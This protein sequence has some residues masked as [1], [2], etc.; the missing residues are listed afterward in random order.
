M[1]FCIIFVVWSILWLFDRWWV[2]VSGK[3]Q[4]LATNPRNLQKATVRVLYSFFGNF[5]NYCSINSNFMINNVI[6]TSRCCLQRS[7]LC[8]PLIINLLWSS[9]H[10]FVG[11]GFTDWHPV[12]APLSCLEIRLHFII[13]YITWTSETEATFSTKWNTDLQFRYSSVSSPY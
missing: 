3:W 10:T 1:C 4:C 9:V 13:S 7:P 12:V 2:E 11:A 5:K 6:F 8:V